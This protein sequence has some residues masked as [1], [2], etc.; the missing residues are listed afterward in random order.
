VLAWKRFKGRSSALL[1][2]LSLVGCGAPDDG[3]RPSSCVDRVAMCADE[4]T[5]GGFS[6]LTENSLYLPQ[7][8]ATA[9]SHSFSGT[10]SVDAVRMSAS[11]REPA[12]RYA[13]PSF[14][15]QFVTLGDV[16]LPLEREI[17][18]GGGSN[19][20][21]IILSPGR[22]WSEPNDG[23]MS[24]ASFPFTLVT[25]EWNEAHNGVATFLYDDVSATH[26]RLQVTQETAPWNRLDFWA[27]TSTR[28]T[29]EVVPIDD[30]RIRDFEDERARRVATKPWP[31]LAVDFPGVEM[32][33]FTR[34]IEQPDISSTGV[35]IDDVLYYQASITRHGAYPYPLE[36]RH[37]AFS[38]TKS[39]GAAL[40]LLHLAQKYGEGVFDLRVS[41]YVEV[42]ASHDGWNGV[43][44][45]HL[46]SMVAGIGERWPDPTAEATYADENDDDSDIWADFWNARTRAAKLAEGFRYGNY[47]WGPGEI[48]RYN[49]VHTFILGAAMDSF[50][51]AM[52]GAD[53]NIWAMMKR[54]VYAPVGIHAVPTM[55]TQDPDPLPI[56]AV[57]LFLNAYDTARIAQLFVNDGAHKGRQL[58][59]AEKTRESLFRTANTGYETQLSVATPVPQKARYL[60]SFWSFALEG[61]GGC[62]ARVPFMWGFGGN[63]VTILPNGVVAYRY[64]DADVHDPR[65]LALAAARL[66][67]L[68]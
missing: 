49:S 21:N 6:A 67:P 64:A 53:A 14:S 66:R 65:A 62:R 55:T 32:A 33:E 3:S 59:H 8:G 28:Y 4:L 1:V 42:T 40:T 31:E 48:V 22:V 25:D 54:E 37:G 34:N 23:G 57:G 44:F 27:V 5:D 9:A 36:M 39:A 38:V 41:D 58:L 26:L 16:L 29:P 60:N 12:G 68:C 52:E 51:K 18:R 20:W 7:P 50:Y 43:T 19:D 47:P 30:Q 45:G 24:R 10:L 15:V 56:N 61:P 17:I 46:L 35:L 11:G 2:A 63:F 13:F